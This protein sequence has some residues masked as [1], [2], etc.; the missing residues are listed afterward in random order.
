MT[1]TGFAI[2]IGGL[3]SALLTSGLLLPTPYVVLCIVFALGGLSV[4]VAIGIKREKRLNHQTC[5]PATINADKQ[6]FISARVFGLVIAMALGDFLYLRGQEA[7]TNYWLLTDGQQGIATV[8]SELW[9]GHNAVEY[10]YIVNR[11]DYTGKSGRNWQDPKYGNVQIGGKSVVFFSASHPWLSQLNK[12]RTLIEGLP[13]VIIV[14]VLEAF[15]I[16]TIV[17]PR[18]GWAFNFNNERKTSS[19]TER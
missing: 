3:G 7:W 2:F 4:I 17:N 19:K 15:A 16:I 18:S 14:L 1:V 6:N 10:N 5:N 12:P 11:A 13:V 9:S 8:T